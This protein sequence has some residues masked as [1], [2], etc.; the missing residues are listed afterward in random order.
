MRHHISLPGEAKWM[1][2]NLLTQKW[3]LAKTIANFCVTKAQLVSKCQ[4]VVLYHK[5]NWLIMSQLN[6][7]ALVLAIS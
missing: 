7:I 6:F 2:G 1:P 4:Y 5:H 3:G